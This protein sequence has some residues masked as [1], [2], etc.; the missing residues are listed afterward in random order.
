MVNLV[1]FTAAVSA[2]PLITPVIPIK[3]VNIYRT[4]LRP[5]VISHLIKRLK[6]IIKSSGNALVITVRQ[7]YRYDNLRYKCR[8][9]GNR[10]YSDDI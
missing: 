2:V 6:P 10:K 4:I 1:A 5:H 7:K 9:K 8:E 3:P